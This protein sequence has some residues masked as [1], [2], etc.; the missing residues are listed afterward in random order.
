[1]SEVCFFCDEYQSGMVGFA[2]TELWRA[3]WDG[4]P[5]TPG[6]ALLIPKRHA[7][8]LEELTAAESDSLLPFVREVIKIINVTDLLQLY[9]DMEKTTDQQGAT[10][11]EHALANLQQ[12]ATKPSAFNYG[13]N[14][15]PEAGQ[16]VPHFH[17]HIMPR[18]KGDMLNPRGGVRN[19]FRD[20]TYGEL[21]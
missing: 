5:A 9:T 21:S 4:R 11:I 7:Q 15:G 8:Y 1:M 2:E 14:D 19:L 17:F 12:R 6:H 16:S 18:W 3:R 20:D 10:F 13:V